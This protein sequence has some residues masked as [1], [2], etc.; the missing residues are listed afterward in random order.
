MDKPDLDELER[1]LAEA[2]GGEWGAG[3][4]GSD[5]PCQCPYIFDGGQYAGG[6]GGVYIDNGKNIADGGNDCPPREEAIANL[7]L[8]IAAHNALP[9]LIAIARAAQ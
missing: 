3:C 8:I 1:L 4:L 5:S 7:R 2:S 9:A 6:I